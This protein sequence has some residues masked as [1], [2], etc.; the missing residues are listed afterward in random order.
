MHNEELSNYVKRAREVGMDDGEI[1]RELLASGWQSDDIDRNLNGGGYGQKDLAPD[2]PVRLLKAKEILYS[3][4]VVFNARRK[5]AFKIVLLPVIAA[6]LLSLIVVYAASFLAGSIAG[7][8]IIVL[9]T[10]ILA[11]TSV[12]LSAI[13]FI[14]LAYLFNGKEV[15]T[16]SEYI[17]L[18]LKKFWPYAW[19]IFLTS[20]LVLGGYMLLIVPGIMF[21]IWFGLAFYALIIEDRKGM[22]ALLRSK[23]LVSGKFWKTAWRFLFI[24]LVALLI[25]APFWV[26]DYLIKSVDLSWLTRLVE[27]VVTLPLGVAYYTI[28][29][30]NLVQVKTEPFVYDKKSARNFIIVGFV[31]VL[32]MLALL[33]FGGYY[34]FTKLR[35]LLLVPA[36]T[37]TADW[38]TYTNPQYGFEFKYPN[39]L[40]TKEFSEV[41]DNQQSGRGVTLDGLSSN[42]RMGLSIDNTVYVGGSPEMTISSTMIQGGAFEWHKTKGYAYQILPPRDWFIRYSTNINGHS[43]VFSIYKDDGTGADAGTHPIDVA[44][45]SMMDQILSTFRLIR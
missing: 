40:T 41:I 45:E 25:L 4:F 11:V 26:I 27:Y 5:L 31:G 12:I 22:G 34:Y 35:P 3:A 18:G 33:A 30:K 23:H 24:W 21:S 43:F 38:K 39:Y 10:V 16:F 28:F 2:G 20:F 7:A 36:T 13:A 9:L 32:L 15:F 14:S 6:V 8:I 1:R 29:F 37:S 17:K 19:I 42:T 44:V